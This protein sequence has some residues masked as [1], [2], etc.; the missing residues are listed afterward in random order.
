MRWMDVLQ[1]NGSA[2]MKWTFEM[3]TAL[4]YKG[5]WGGWTA[6]IFHRVRLAFVCGEVPESASLRACGAG[7]ASYWDGVEKAKR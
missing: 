2:R 7:W 6:G 1:F 5:N 3:S 4:W